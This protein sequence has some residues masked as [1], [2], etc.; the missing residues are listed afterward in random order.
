MDSLIKKYK[1]KLYFV[2]SK[3]FIFILLFILPQ[4]NKQLF[5]ISVIYSIFNISRISL[6]LGNLSR[7][8]LA[9]HVRF[10]CI[11][12]FSQISSGPVNTFFVYL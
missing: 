12:S 9:W 5:K 3:V 2:I 1:K 7:A 11:F 8:L 4:N 6:A 10:V